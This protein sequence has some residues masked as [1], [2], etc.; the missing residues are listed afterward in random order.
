M[1]L[2]CTKT[3]RYWLAQRD[4]QKA[5]HFWNYNIVALNAFVYRSMT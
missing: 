1:K 3:G 5:C 4:K 2:L